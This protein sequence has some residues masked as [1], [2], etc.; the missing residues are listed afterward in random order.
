MVDRLKDKV[1]L[2]TGAGSGIGRA[3]AVLFAKEGAK[4]VAT[5]IDM[6]GANKTAASIGEPSIA[7]NLDVSKE[8]AWKMAVVSA[9]EKFGRLDIVCNVAG[10]GY[11]GTIEDLDMAEWHAMVAVNLTGVML[12]CKYGVKGIRESGGRGAIINVSALGGVVGVSDVAGYCATK[13]GV[14]TLTKSV[15]LYCAGKRLPIRCLSVDPPYVDTEMMDPVVAQF[16]NRQ[17]LMDEL[18]K[19]VPMGR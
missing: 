11:L 3:A 2:I 4:V 14:T 13:G 1:A 7:L 5:D 10:I 16:P 15:A 8:E 6:P 19:F 12:G 9:I 17:A 18:A